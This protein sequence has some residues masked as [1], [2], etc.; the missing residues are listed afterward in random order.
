MT[1]EALISN[2]TA[3]MAASRFGRS[4]RALILTG[5][6]ARGEATFSG[7]PHS[8]RVLGDAEFLLVFHEAFRLPSEQSISEFKAAIENALRD[9]GI[10]IRVGASAVRAAY[11]RALPPE[12]FTFEL[13]AFAK[14]IWGDERV[15]DLIPR[16]TRDQLSKQDAWHLL[17]NRIVEVLEVSSEIDGAISGRTDVLNYRLCKLYL[18][19]ATSFLVFCGAY[20]STYRERREALEKVARTLTRHPAFSDLH[21]FTH[22]VSR[23]TDYKLRSQILDEWYGFGC[24]VSC[25]QQAIDTARGLW[26]WELKQLAKC[27]DIA[28]GELVRVWTD[29]QPLRRRAR[30]WLSA[31]R[32]CGIGGCRY[33]PHW[34][35][36][37]VDGSPR[38]L[39]YAAASDLFFRLTWLRSAQSDAGRLDLKGVSSLLPLPPRATHERYD[40]AWRG[41]AG[42]IAQN[43]HRL[44]ETTRA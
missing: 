27:G 24:E 40:A 1:C 42:S 9:R 17:C 11:F 41:L 18:D 34:A 31:A 7:G 38:Y 30:G 33:W 29:L 32:R 13:G 5:S 12:I 15:L 14:V 44:L 19:M 2:E 25:L 4:L 20:D 23:C 37:A 16:F 35:R 8:W 6:L 26:R 43:Y 36:L 10:S 39:I 28:D 22:V 21:E 3:A